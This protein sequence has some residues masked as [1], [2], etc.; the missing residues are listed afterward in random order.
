M[1]EQ[2]AA[3]IRQHNCKTGCVRLYV[4]TSIMESKSSARFV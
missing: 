2:V 4:G 1:A 3:R